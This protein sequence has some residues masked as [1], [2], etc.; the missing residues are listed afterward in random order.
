MRL[1]ESTVS[2]GF[3]SFSNK[4][5]HLASLLGPIVTL[6][7]QPVT[8]SYDPWMEHCICIISK[9]STI[10]IDVYYNSR[11]LPVP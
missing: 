3:S 4:I 8:F 2:I 10:L 11:D 6:C 1:S 9:P 7:A 5:G